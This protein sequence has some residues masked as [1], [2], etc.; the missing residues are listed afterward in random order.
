M[1]TQVDGST[2]NSALF[3]IR[4]ISGAMAASCGIYAMLI[5]V[6]LQQGQGSED[7]HFIFLAIALM[8]AVTSQV[9]YRFF[10][11][12]PITSPTTEQA[13]SFHSEARRV[14]TEP[15]HARRTFVAAEFTPHIL[16]LAL[17]EVPAVIAIA[18]Y[19]TGMPMTIALALCG[20][21]VLLLLAA[22]PRASAW[23]AAAEARFGAVFDK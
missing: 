13:E 11:R 6:F 21:S 23:Q 18:G 9:I 15:A 5:T 16:R 14:L 1:A 10:P 7:L 22:F 4:I 2:W 3:T 17:S 19:L 20:L 8:S 12:P